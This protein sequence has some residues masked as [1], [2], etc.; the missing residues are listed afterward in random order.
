MNSDCLETCRHRTRMSQ[1]VRINAYHPVRDVR[2]LVGFPIYKGFIDF[3]GFPYRDFFPYKPTC[4]KIC[5][6]KFFLA[7]KRGGIGGWAPAI[8]MFLWFVGC[9]FSFLPV[10][11]SHLCLAHVDNLINDGKRYNMVGMRRKVWIISRDWNMRFQHGKNNK[12]LVMNTQ[13]Y[14]TP[15]F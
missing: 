9:T 4:E 14:Y 15:D 5:L 13:D 6:P 8:P 3:I 10:E 2:V 7:L 11:T 12:W 1:E